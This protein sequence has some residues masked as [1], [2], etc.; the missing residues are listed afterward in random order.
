MRQPFSKFATQAFC[1]LILGIFANELATPAHA[2][3][4][5]PGKH[6]GVVVFDR[7]DTCFLLSGPYVTYISSKLKNELRRYQGKAMQIDASDVFQPMNPG[8]ALIRKYTAIRPAPDNHRWAVL[9]GLKLVA[10]SDFGERRIP[11]FLIEIHNAG[12]AVVDIDSSEIGPTLLGPTSATPLAVSDGH[13]VALITR[14]DVLHPSS[15][16][17]MIAR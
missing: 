14:G 2:G 9:D 10:R 5:G 13:S 1:A 8:D 15:W 12:R 17:S 4:R 16:E 11:I 7:W 6:S 3:L